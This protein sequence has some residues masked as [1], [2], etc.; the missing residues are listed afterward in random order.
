MSYTI[1]SSVSAVN[2]L[3]PDLSALPNGATITYNSVMGTIASLVISFT[4]AVLPLDIVVVAQGNSSGRQSAASTPQP[5]TDPTPTPNLVLDAANGKTIKYVGTTTLSPNPKFILENPRNKAAGPEWFAVVDD[6]SKSSITDYAKIGSTAFT[7]SG[8]SPVPFN[9]IV[10]TRVTDMNGVFMFAPGFNEEIGSWDTSNVTDM[11]N[12]FTN[13]F[14]FNQDISAWNTS[15][16]AD[17]TAMFYNASAFNQP[18]GSWNTFSVVNMQYMFNYASAFNQNIS[19]WNVSKV[20]I[21]PPNQFRD[22][23]A[24]SFGNQPI[25]IA[26]TTAKPVVFNA[27]TVSNTPALISKFG[28]S[29]TGD[30]QMGGTPYGIN[31][32]ASGNIYV[33]DTDNHRIQKFD[34]S[35]TYL[36]KFGSFGGSNTKFY[37]PQDITINSTGQILVVDYYNGAIKRFTS[38][39]AYVSK[40]G[41]G[42]SFPLECPWAFGIDMSD[43][44]YVAVKEGHFIQKYSS[45]G[46]YSSQFGSFG[47]G[48]GQFNNPSDIALDASGNIYVVDSLNHRIQKFTTDGVYISQ[49]GSYGTGNGQFNEPVGIAIDAIGKILI[50]DMLNHRIQIFANNGTYIGKFGSY[51]TGDEQF[52]RPL[53]VAIDSNGKIYVSNGNHNNDQIKIFG[54]IQRVL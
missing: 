54:D 5:L 43:N 46:V 9:N 28:S 53:A 34:S 4:N 24:L 1:Q 44:I 49:F 2:V 21:K 14:N 42:F 31:L 22:Y 23:S 26:P 10:T 12:A 45:D 17:M 51:G 41:Q 11:T 20:T 19:G 15:K 32:D 13:A 6:S 40:F 30:G 37:Y 27:G 47:A 48:N 29:G 8:A 52:N 7:P 39:G 33:A 36:S 18:I 35:G 16:V 25:W 38:A 3:K 50:V